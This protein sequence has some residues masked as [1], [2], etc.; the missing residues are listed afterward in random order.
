LAVRALWICALLALIA[1]SVLGVALPADEAAAQ[2]IGGRN[3]KDTSQGGGVVALSWSSGT[4]QTGYRLN[5]ITSTGSVVLATLGSTATSFTDNLGTQVTVACYQLEVLG[6]NNAVVGTSPIL[7]NIVNLAGGST[8]PRNI[9]ITG[10]TGLLTIDWDAST[11][12]NE[13]GYLVVPLGQNPLPLLPNTITVA[14]T[15]AAEPT[16]FIVLALI[17]D[18]AQVPFQIGGFS[19]I[20]C[21]VGPATGQL[22]PATTTPT[23]T[24]TATATAPTATVPTATSATSTITAT[25]T[26]TSTPSPTQ[27]L[28]PIDLTISKVDQPDP[29]N[30]GQQVTYTITVQN[31]GQT[32]ST[33]VTVTDSLPAGLTYGSAADTTPSGPVGFVCNET[34]P[35]GTI[36]C[37][38]GAIPGGGSAQIT[39]VAIVDNPC[40]VVSPVTNQAS[41]DP[42][43]TI[44]ESNEGNNT[45][46]QATTI[47]GCVQATGTA[48]QTRTPTLTRTATG[49]P[50]TTATP[51]VDLVINKVDQPDPVTVPGAPAQASLQYTISVQNLG[52]V[53]ASNISVRDDLPAGEGADYFFGTATGDQGFLCDFNFAAPPV[54]TC[55]GGNI[56]PGGGATISVVLN[57]VT[58]GTPFYTNTATVDPANTIAEFNEGNNLIQQTTACGGVGT[59]VPTATPPTS[60]TATRTSTPTLTPTAVPTASFGFLKLESSDPVINGSVLTYTLQLTNTSA[61]DPI[62]GVSLNDALPSQVSFGSFGLV[63]GGF[64][65]EFVPTNGPEGGLVSCAGGLIPPATTVI[66]QI[67]VVVTSCVSPIVNTATILSPPVQNSTATSSTTV[68][69]PGGGPC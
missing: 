17:P 29:V 16:C 60:P 7:C 57:F 23:R 5:K 3:F 47:L 36:V 28:T 43:N 18:S 6:T 12:G 49:T 15:A 34:S 68:T 20:K 62:P 31:L 11:A 69:Q 45:A 42:S 10:D 2:A 58:C 26:T 4:G 22:V 44:A 67:D 64:N 54:V 1:A 53:G 40:V 8:R 19:D 51:A 13:V 59:V 46:S 32:N 24:S 35:P 48:T 25:T 9:S 50:T 33:A 63:G 55:T 14:V 30:P 61:T 27:T 66:I 56:G 52:T 21:W 38:G 39:L 65:C 41:V 37:T